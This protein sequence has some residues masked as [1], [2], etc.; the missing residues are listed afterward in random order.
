M[1]TSLPAN[2]ELR[3]LSDGLR[4]DGRGVVRVVRFASL[5]LAAL[6]ILPGFVRA[7][8]I[9]YDNDTTLG[10]VGHL[11]D[12]QGVLGLDFNVN[13][14]ITVT[15]LGAYDQGSVGN[16]IGSTG[17]GVSVGIFDRTTGTLVSPTAS[18]SP[19][20]AGIQIN[21]D[22]FQPELFT[23]APGQYSVVSLNDDNYNEGY[24]SHTFNP[25]SVM[26]TGGGAISFVGSGRYDG[27]GS[28]V[29]PTAVDGGPAN[30]YDAGTFIFETPE[31][32]TFVLLL[33]SAVVGCVCFRRRLKVQAINCTP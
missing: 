26:N 17:Q 13:Q 5:T 19:I 31:P 9:A 12:W 8:T 20:N 18:F 2:R 23:L 24:V 22:A 10:D 27:G 15:A 30:R 6:L 14:Q 33:S 29:Y 21:G 16:L 32:S 7:S 1:T 4:R 11:Q 28:L 3:R 25:T